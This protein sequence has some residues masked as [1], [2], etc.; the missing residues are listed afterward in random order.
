[1]KNH[2]YSPCTRDKTWNA[3]IIEEEPYMCYSVGTREVCNPSA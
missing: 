3:E 2:L 1:M